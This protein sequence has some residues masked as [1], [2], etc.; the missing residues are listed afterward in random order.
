MA[1]KAFPEECRAMLQDVSFGLCVRK[2]EI[3]TGMEF[4]IPY[5]F[6]SQYVIK[7]LILYNDHNESFRG[8]GSI[9]GNIGIILKA[10]M[11]TMI[12]QCVYPYELLCSSVKPHIVMQVYQELY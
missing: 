12:C 2:L 4:S 8:G 7:S 10:K 11:A 6:H 3:W 1:L 5:I 9:W